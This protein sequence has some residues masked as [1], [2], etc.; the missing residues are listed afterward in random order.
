[1]TDIDLPK[2]S[3]QPLYQRIKQILCERIDSGE[4]EEGQFLPPERD[5]AKA[6]GVNRLTLRRA[7]QEL[8]TEGYLSRRRGMGTLV[9]RRQ[10]K[11]LKAGVVV[12][13]GNES[14]LSNSFYG[15]ILAA[16]QDEAT[17]NDASLTF[18]SAH[19]DAPDRFR[20]VAREEGFS[21]FVTVGI[22][23]DD[24]IKCI[25][26]AGL[27]LVLVDY[28]TTKAKTDAVTVD[29]FGGGKEAVEY[30]ISLGHR[31]IGYVGGLRGGG[32]AGLWKEHS[33]EERG[34]GYQ[35]ALKDAGIGNAFMVEER[36]DVE[37][38]RVGAKR[39]LDDHPGLTA[40]FTF[41]DD[42]AAGVM[43]ECEARGLKVPDDMSVAGFGD[44]PHIRTLVTPRLTTIRIDSAREIGRAAMRKLKERVSGKDRSARSVQAIPAK[45]VIGDSCA[46]PRA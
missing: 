38:G 14:A 16:M 30:L 13:G 36:L 32:P 21:G 40:I 4:I 12:Y 6:F 46:K 2:L 5:L 31:K 19:G 22:M 15:Q 34:R 24:E 11:R 43:R 28:A 29:D 45:L 37:G 33:S 26:R 41:S 8:E 1:M 10:S 23:D 39:L 42:M 35:A 9:L 20:D 3:P 7:V 44:M 18:V 17:R 25:A 27:P